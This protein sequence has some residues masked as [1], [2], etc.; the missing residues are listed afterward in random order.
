M[1]NQIDQCPNQEITLRSEPFPFTFI[2]DPL[3]PQNLENVPDL[4]KDLPSQAP[5]LFALPKTLVDV[6]MFIGT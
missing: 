1:G 6:N 3:I 5:A 4:L 2:W